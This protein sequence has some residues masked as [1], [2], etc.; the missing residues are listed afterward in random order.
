MLEDAIKSQQVERVAALLEQG[1]SPN[2]ERGSSKVGCVS[3]SKSTSS[4][5]TLTNIDCLP[6]PRDGRK[7][8][9]VMCG[10]LWVADILVFS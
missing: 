10:G 5:V 9:M 7:L 2:G 4:V 8:M 1:C 6:I 3:K